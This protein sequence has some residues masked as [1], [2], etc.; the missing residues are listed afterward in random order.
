MVIVHQFAVLKEN[1]SPCECRHIRFVR[2][3][4]DR[5]V[6]FFIEISEELH[7]LDA[8]RTVKTARRFVSKQQLRLDDNR[9]GDCYALLLTAG[10]F[11]RRMVCPLKETTRSSAAA[12]KR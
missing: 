9:S 5:D 11:C 8:A 10:E 2:N 6:L 1:V 12:A 3:E 4:S 7:N